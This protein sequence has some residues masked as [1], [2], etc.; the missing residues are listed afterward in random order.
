MNGILNKVTQNKKIW[1]RA[2]PKKVTNKSGILFLANDW[3]V[4][5]DYNKHYL[6]SIQ[7]AI[8]AICQT[9]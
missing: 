8:T 5:T 1:Y 3:K 9:F 7:I 2:P 6:F 4:V